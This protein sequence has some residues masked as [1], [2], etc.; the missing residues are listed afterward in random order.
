MPTYHITGGTPLQ[1]STRVG[2]AKNASYKLMIAALLGNTPSR[3]LNFSH[4]ND[5]S[6][7]ADVIRD[8]GAEARVVGERAYLVDSAAMTSWIVPDKYGAVSRASTLFIPVLLARFGKAQVPLPGGDKIGVRNL[9]FHFDGLKALGAEVSLKGDVLEV[10]ASELRGTTYRFA[11]NSHTGTE[12]MI[13]LAVKAQG[14][15]ILENAAEETEIDDLIKFLNAMGAQV[16]RHPQRVIEIRGVS[17][18]HGAIH[19]IM[20]DQN[21]VV[22]FA[23]AA[24]ASKGDVIVENARAKDILAFLEKLDEIGA[25]YEVGS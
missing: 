8:L 15:T 10:V 18:L 1:G 5:V 22:S 6:M 14:T 16:Q 17:Q 11:K 9:D 12:T 21:Q 19:K 23:C 3:L 7:V 25:G 24:L 2:G 4:I 20:S 13:M